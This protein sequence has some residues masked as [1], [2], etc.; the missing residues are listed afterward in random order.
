MYLKTQIYMYSYIH[1]CI[2]LEFSNVQTCVQKLKVSFNIQERLK[3]QSVVHSCHACIQAFSSK[4]Q[5]NQ[6]QVQITFMKNGLYVVCSF[7]NFQ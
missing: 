1:T 6:T 3:V 2:Q 7:L 4:L 5:S